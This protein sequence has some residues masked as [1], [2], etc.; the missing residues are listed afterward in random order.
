MVTVPFFLVFAAPLV[1]PS[2]EYYFS[3]TYHSMKQMNICIIT[4]TCNYTF[5]GI[6]TEFLVKFFCF[7]F[8]L[9]SIMK[10][11]EEYES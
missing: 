3:S 2:E 4:S 6:I 9:T 7:V 8:Y 5:D 1:C 11:G 10:F